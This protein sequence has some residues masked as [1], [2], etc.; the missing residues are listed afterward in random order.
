MPESI[1]FIVPI[2]MALTAWLADLPSSWPYSDMQYS[3]D[4]STSLIDT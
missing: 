1:E 4:F 2:K 3:E